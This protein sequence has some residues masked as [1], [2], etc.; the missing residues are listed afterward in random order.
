MLRKPYKQVTKTKSKINMHGAEARTRFLELACAKLQ[1]S[2]P[3]TKF[4]ARKNNDFPITSILHE[5]EALPKYALLWGQSTISGV[6][7][8]RAAAPCSQNLFFAR[9]NDDC[10]L[11]QEVAYYRP[12]DGPHDAPRDRR[13]HFLDLD[14]LMRRDHAPKEL[15]LLHGKSNIL[16]FIAL[17]LK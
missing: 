3:K 16:C 12:K 11:D 13:Q 10:V 4:F 6:T 2:A 7:Q 15:H 14:P 1:S 8:T 9:K 17:K 5:N